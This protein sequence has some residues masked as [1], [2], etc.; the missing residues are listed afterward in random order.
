MT[1][2][3]PTFWPQ[4]GPDMD[5]IKQKF[6]FQSI[7]K[8]EAILLP[9]MWLKNW[10]TKVKTSKI[11]TFCYFWPKMGKNFILISFKYGVSSS[12]SLQ[13]L[14]KYFY[15]PYFVL[16]NVY[17]MQNIKKSSLKYQ[18][19]SFFTILDQILPKFCPKCYTHTSLFLA[20]FQWNMLGD[21]IN[22]N[23]LCCNPVVLKKKL[24]KPYNFVWLSPICTKKGSLWAT[25]KIENNFLLAEIT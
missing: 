22:I 7:I 8:T 3:G 4:K 5:F 16:V 24:V 15:D 18:F 11:V 20:D 10:P 6:N 9:S 25:P 21:S 2:P 1:Q 13:F 12:F 17:L 19:L 23:N 14:L